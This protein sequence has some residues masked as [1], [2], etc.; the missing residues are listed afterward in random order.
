M[1]A[2][3]IHPIEYLKL[4]LHVDFGVIGK[5]LLVLPVTCVKKFLIWR[6]GQ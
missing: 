1:S 5:R 4:H 2:L 6:I 3:S